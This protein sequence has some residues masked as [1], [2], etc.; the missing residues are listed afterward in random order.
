MFALRLVADVAIVSPVLAPTW[1]V[2]PFGAEQR[3]TVELG[4]VLDA[5]DFLGDLDDL[6]GDGRLVVVAEGAVVVLDLE[7]TDALQHRVHL[8]E[9]TFS[10]LDERDAVL[11]V[12]L[13][14]SQA[15]DLA[16][17]L[18]RDGEAGSVV[19]RRG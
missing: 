1:N 9:G 11:R 16:A 7:V 12:A 5:L 14:L 15:A 19:S 3:L 13:R 17:H 10:G 18:L 6:R 4:L 8:V 2:K